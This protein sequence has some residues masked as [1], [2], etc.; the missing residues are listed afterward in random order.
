MEPVGITDSKKLTRRLRQELFKK[1]VAIGDVGLGIATAK[2]IDSLNILKATMLA[3]QRAFNNLKKK[4]EKALVDG[5]H[6]PKLTI[7]TECVIKGDAKIRAISAASI[8][9]KVTRDEIMAS[10]AA[11]NPGY[12]WERNAGYG[13][14]EHKAGLVKLG[15]SSHHRRSYAPIKQLLKFPINN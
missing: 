14:S 15:V 5:N 13:T 8:I 2:E 11:V 3:M 12:G 6:S 1:I 9:A 7:Q 10:L 4:P